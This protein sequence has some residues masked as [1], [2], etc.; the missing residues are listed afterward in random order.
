PLRAS[1]SRPTCNGSQP[2]PLL[3]GAHA[4]IRFQRGCRRPCS[5]ALSPIG[6]A[7]EPL[8]SG[9]DSAA[10]PPL[11]PPTPGGLPPTPRAPGR[12]P[13]G[14]RSHSPHGPARS[15]PTSPECLEGGSFGG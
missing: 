1:C 10:L 8:L 15:P 3:G 4:A 7:V 13:S 9:R 6:A 12:S 2:L 5:D 11:R 14:P